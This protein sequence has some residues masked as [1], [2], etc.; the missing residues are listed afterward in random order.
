MGIFSNRLSTRDHLDNLNF[1]MYLLDLKKQ[2]TQ[3]K[4]K[5]LKELAD[6]F[7]GDI[8]KVKG[9]IRAYNNYQ[10]FRNCA[11]ETFGG[12]QES[13]EVFI[14]AVQGK[15]EARE[16]TQRFIGSLMDH[17]AKEAA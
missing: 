5:G 14:G 4:Y 1:R 10:T 3:E 6:S 17:L 16:N 13:L 8:P 9:P 11:E 12:I 15:P 7:E 2:I